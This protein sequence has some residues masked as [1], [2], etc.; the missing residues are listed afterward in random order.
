M[1]I[2][3]M[4]EVLVISSSTRSS[5]MMSPTCT[6]L[7]RNNWPNLERMA[8]KSAGNVVTA[9]AQSKDRELWRLIHGLGI[10][11]VGEGG[12]RK[13]ADHFH[14]LNALASADI[15]KLQEAE[16][17]GPVMAQSIHD[18]FNNPRNQ[19]VIEKLRKA[20]VKMKQKAAARKPL[21]TG[22]SPEKQSS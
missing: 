17:V 16:D 22:R 7:L 4:G 21:P 5:F 10:L 6:R 2:D 8:E 14:D 12:A 11:H 19:A 15:E 1:D 20:G 18:F 13:L 3:G 9:I